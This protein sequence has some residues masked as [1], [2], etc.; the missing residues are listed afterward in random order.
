MNR[1][2][3]TVAACLAAAIFVPWAQAGDLPQADPPAQQQ[4]PHP[5]SSPQPAESAEP[6]PAAEAARELR[7]AVQDALA[8]SAYLRKPNSRQ[9]RLRGQAE[10][11]SLAHRLL[12]LHGRLEQS[13][14]LASSQRARLSIHVRS[15][16]L[17]LADVL[18]R[19]AADQAGAPVVPSAR[20]DDET[21]QRTPP[22]AAGGAAQPGDLGLELVELI[23]RTVAPQTWDVNG[24]QG[25][26]RYWAP[27]HV[28]VV[29]QTGEVHGQIGGVV[30][31]LRR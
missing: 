7:A 27:L 30:R 3:A 15:R 18:A 9:T 25:T 29:R 19:R 21:G 23:Q 17:A 1:L 26:I 12:D 31:G 8:Q 6:R 2:L 11:E 4:P 10:L 24:G 28:L 20:D 16:L 22:G 13:E 14:T 5:S